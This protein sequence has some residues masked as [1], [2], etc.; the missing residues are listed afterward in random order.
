MPVPVPVAWPLEIVADWRL[1][2]MEGPTVT[3]G[4]YCERACLTMERATR[5]AA[6]A[7]AIFWFDTFTC[8]SSAFNC[9][10]L[11]ISH[12]LPFSAASFGCATLQPS[13]V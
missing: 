5:N 9:G 13:V 4:K 1:F 3:V 10:S 7:E 12:H 6:A 2:V 8:S 11:N